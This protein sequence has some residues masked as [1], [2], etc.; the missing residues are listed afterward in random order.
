MAWQREL[1]GG[2]VLSDDRGR[3]DLEVVYH[4]LCGQAYWAI[5]RDRRVVERSVEHSLCLGLYAPDGA[6]VGFARAIT[7]RAV[8]AHLVDVF[9]LPAF[10][11]RG[12]GR[13]LVGAM[14][15]HPE[16]AEVEC[17]T[18][19]TRDAQGLYAGFGFVVQPEPESQMIWRRRWR[20]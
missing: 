2:F 16:L 5:G 3:L 10:R 7:D 4:Y 9:V 13:A 12:L 6:Q 1:V 20:D 11:G 15:G 14:L 19:S 17:W 18:L 8:R